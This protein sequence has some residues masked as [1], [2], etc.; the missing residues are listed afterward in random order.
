MP[1][2][3]VGTMERVWK[4]GEVATAHSF[5]NI[6]SNLPSWK[7]GVKNNLHIFDIHAEVEEFLFDA[8]NIN[9]ET[10]SA[11]ELLKNEIQWKSIV[12]PDEWAAKRFWNMFE[13]FD[14]IVCSKKRVWWER[15][16]E[17]KEWDPVWKDLI[18]I[19]DL[20]QTWGTIIEAS[21][22]L[23]SLWAKSVSA[24]ASHWVFPNNSHIALAKNV[25][26]LIVSDSI[27]ENNNRVWDI[28]NMEILKI[29]NLVK[30]IITQNY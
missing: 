17:V 21:V 3:P 13:W 14:K 25:D 5:A 23:K 10:H 2:F 15:I 11:F 18:I 28:E 26:K 24:F 20:I 27:P 4:P 29:K 19:D 7:S 16:I 22:K 12:F 8:K 6:L 30:E 9:V 1:Y